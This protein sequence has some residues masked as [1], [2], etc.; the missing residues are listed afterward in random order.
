MKPWQQHKVLARCEL[1]RRAPAATARQLGN[2]PAHSFNRIRTNATDPRL[3]V[4]YRFAA[5]SLA[6]Q[7]GAPVGTGNIFGSRA[8]SLDGFTSLWFDAGKPQHATCQ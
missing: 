7:V 4:R 3:A 1:K 6:Q 5:A 2:M 8:N